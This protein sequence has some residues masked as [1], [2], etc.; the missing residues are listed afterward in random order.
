MKRNTIW[1]GVLLLTLM[2]L[3]AS[4]RKEQRVDLSKDRLVF[5]YSGGNDVFQITANCD[6]T[7]TGM[8]DWI[9]VNPASGSK[10]GNVAVHVDRNFSFVDRSALL[11]VVSA[12]NKVKKDIEVVQTPVD[13]S[14]ITRKVWFVR[15]EERWN[16]DYWDVVIPESYRSWTFY[17]DAGREQWFFYFLENQTGY[18]IHIVDNDTVYYPYQFVY[19][20]D[21]DSLYIRFEMINATD[22]IEDYHT[23][24]QQLD[25]EYLVFSHAYRP[26]QF[27]KVTS[28]NVTGDEK[29]TFRINPKKIRQKPKGPFIT[30][31]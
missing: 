16:S 19:Q 9:T 10:D 23:T 15:T 6:W 29:K 18:E 5:T 14:N 21:Y 17:A 1:V 28:V 13:I 26:H 20:P 24:I 31:K 7:V 11:T 8:P 27:E 4:C 30:V 12:N 2:M 22:S 25:N 3:A